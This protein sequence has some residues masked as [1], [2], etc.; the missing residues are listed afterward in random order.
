MSND[1]QPLSRAV[2]CI[3][4]GQGL[5]G[6]TDRPSAT[7]PE[8]T[9]FV[10]RFRDEGVPHAGVAEIDGVI[11]RRGIDLHQEVPRPTRR[12][13]VVLKPSRRPPDSRC[14]L[15]VA[16]ARR[17]VGNFE[18]LYSVLDLIRDESI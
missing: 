16:V 15:E 5:R 11:I 1:I 13:L 10:A 9:C 18:R 3:P 17:L 4:Q 6:S 2:R 12:W 7:L 8:K 14:K